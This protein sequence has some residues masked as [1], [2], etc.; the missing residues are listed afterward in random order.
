MDT[1]LVI[2][3][4]IKHCVGTGE[5]SFWTIGITTNPKIKKEALGHPPCW[6]MWGADTIHKAKKIESYFLKEFPPG[7]ASGRMKT[8]GTEHLEDNKMPYVYIF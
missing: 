7:P 4:K 8:G 1:S 2:K 3:E 5:Y 6:Q